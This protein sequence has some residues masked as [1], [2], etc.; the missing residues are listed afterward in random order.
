[1]QDSAARISTRPVPRYDTLLSMVGFPDRKVQNQRLGSGFLVRL[2][3]IC[4]NVLLS[5]SLLLLVRHDKEAPASDQGVK[6]SAERE[7]GGLTLQDRSPVLG[8]DYFD[9]HLEW[10]VPK[11]GTAALSGLKKTFCVYQR[12]SKN[13]S[14]LLEDT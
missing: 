1:M 7:Q 8:T 10:I 9:L 6:P 14:L 3:V 2:H 11:N 5:L 4:F 13:S 12:Y